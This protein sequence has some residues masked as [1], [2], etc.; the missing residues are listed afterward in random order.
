[1]PAA[2][3]ITSHTH[4]PHEKTKPKQAKA[5]G[6]FSQSFYL[7]GIHRYRDTGVEKK[8]KSKEINTIKTDS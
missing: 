8:K 5:E 1:M 6:T 4:H 7:I 2:H 3:H